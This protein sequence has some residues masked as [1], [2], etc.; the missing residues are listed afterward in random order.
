M[1]SFS[2]YQDIRNRT[3]GEIYLGVVGPVRTGKSTFIRRFM[4]TSVLPLVKDEALREEMRDELPQ[5][6]QG[7][8]IMTTEPKFV[9]AKAVEL[10][11]D[12][13]TRCKV[14]LIDCVGFMIEGVEGHQENG[15]ERMV[16]TPW[17]D[18]EVS[19]QKAATIGTE[20]VIHDHATLGVVMTTDGS[21]TEISRQNYEPAEEE[22]VRQLKKIGKPFVMI[23]NTRRPYASE[24][25][26]LVQE[27]RQKYDVTVVPMN[28]EQMHEKD[29]EELLEQLL[30][31]FP[32]TR[33]YFSTP[34]WTQTLTEESEVLSSFLATARGILDSCHSMRDIRTQ[35]PST[36]EGL[37]TEV[38]KKQ[39]EPAKGEVTLEF[40]IPGKCYYEYV[41]QLTKE[42]VK[43]EAELL[44][45]LK[46]LSAQKG[47]LKQLSEAYEGVG[48]KGYG[49]LTPRLS[50]IAID[51]PE[52]VKHG[53]KY[54]I[55]IKAFSPS[56]HLIRA[57]I[58]TEIAPIIGSKEQAEDLLNYM[59]KEGK[60]KEDFL[61]INIF[62]KT[63][64]ELIEDGM[65]T[66]IAMMD[67]ESQ[68]KLQESME[69]IV[70]DLNGGMVC[71]II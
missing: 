25:T 22:T 59:V 8:T 56:V 9:P 65:R 62:G 55:R 54:G 71:I 66:K 68:L 30:Y 49:V 20:K 36:G 28:V 34:E 32:I 5:G 11:L 52:L 27:L 3:G 2:V 60:A 48:Q 40:V 4:E 24:T 47:R 10:S 19:F 39:V 21:F 1:E 53:N 17:F 12:E 46:D 45:L 50:E 58:E 7:K 13:Q 35:L 43:N 63:V 64:G 38:V 57:N 41:T 16:H 18:T 6:A 61:N 33:W 42:E 26:E 29:V 15:K 14:R 51:Q 69:K 31:E 44:E 70:N 67:E 23:L 37:V